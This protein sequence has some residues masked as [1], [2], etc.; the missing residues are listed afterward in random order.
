MRYTKEWR[1]EVGFRWTIRVAVVWCALAWALCNRCCASLP[2]GPPDGSCD[3]ISRERYEAAV[4]RAFEGAQVIDLR[5]S[6]ISSVVVLR[7]VIKIPPPPVPVLVKSF[8]RDH[9]PPVLKPTFSR[10]GVCGATILGRY[11]AVLET[12][13]DKEFEDILRHELVHAY[14]T[15]ASPKPLPFWFQEAS[16]VMFSTGKV[17]KFYGKPSDT[18]PRM[19]VGKI[20]ELDPTYRQKLHSLDY[21]LEKAGRQ[22]FYRWYRKSVMTGQVDPQELLGTERREREHERTASTSLPAWLWLGGAGVVV[23]ILAVGAYV[24]RRVGEV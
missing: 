22:R 15:L 8:R 2:E 7:E 10:P 11:V 17:R 5:R 18:Q 23:V 20:V 4:R 19:I 21:L 16:A 3:R 1:A 12:G 14:I 9:L 13:F 24:S 6:R